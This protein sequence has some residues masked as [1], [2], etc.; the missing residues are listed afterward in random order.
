MISN[1]SS[2]IKK[3]LRY[4]N[5]KQETIFLIYQPKYKGEAEVSF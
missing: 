5:P 2:Q 1:Q 4:Y 3:T